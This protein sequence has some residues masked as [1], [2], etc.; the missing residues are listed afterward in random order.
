[1]FGCA[2]VVERMLCSSLQVPP[3]PFSLSFSLSPLFFSFSFF[4]PS[5]PHPNHRDK[6]LKS[7]PVINNA[8]Q[9]R[10]H[11]EEANSALE[12]TEKT[13]GTYSRMFPF[14]TKEW[15]ECIELRRQ[16][17]ER[18]RVTELCATALKHDPESNFVNLERAVQVF[19][20]HFII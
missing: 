17:V 12:F 15:L 16:L 8:L 2:K 3:T 1:M 13:V 10:I 4:L 9:T 7:R 11:L 5:H 19:R 14:R 18:K 6:L 20:L